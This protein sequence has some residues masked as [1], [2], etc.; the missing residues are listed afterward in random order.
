MREFQTETI[1]AG[2]NYGGISP[3][4]WRR[5]ARISRKQYSRVKGGN[6]GEFL[7]RNLEKVCANFKRI[8]F[9]GRKLWGNFSTNLK[10]V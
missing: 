7:T 5:Y 2:G 9:G 10:K 3:E 8:N 4:I 6:N 1:L